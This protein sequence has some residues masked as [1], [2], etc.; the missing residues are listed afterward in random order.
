MASG[1]GMLPSPRP[2]WALFLD[3][4]GTLI[5]HA[6]H[7]EGVT[8][9]K[10]LPDRL[11]AAQT[12]LDGAVAL[13][14]GRTI[15][16]MDRKFAPAR[17]AASGQHGAEV[18]LAPDAPAVPIPMPKWRAPLE[19]A[20]K[21]DLDS[22][23]GVFIEHKPLSLAVHFRAVPEFGDAVMERVMALGR[24]LDDRVQFLHGRYVIEVR[25]A[26]HHKGTAVTTLMNT[27]VFTGRTPVFLGDDVTDED[28]FAAVRD[29][30]G[31]A[32]AVGPRAT[33]QADFH[34]SGPTRVRAWLA[35][36]PAQLVKVAS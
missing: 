23:P 22:W 2:D 13:I 16:W 21:R 10:D 17:L 27:A 35:A 11:T 3:I 26:G 18:R 7:P 4:D 33:G 28:G 20:L 19:A 30:G 36:L 6:D 1:Y 5:E 29:M 12:A 34:M 25:E 9:P 32:I 31:I 15:D 8:I 14:S 24:G